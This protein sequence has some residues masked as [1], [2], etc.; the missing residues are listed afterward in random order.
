[1]P[2]ADEAP[3]GAADERPAWAG[4]PQSRFRHPSP[5]RFLTDRDLVPLVKV[6]RR[7]RGA[8]SPVHW[9]GENGDRPLFLPQLAQESPHLPPAVRQFR[10]AVAVASNIH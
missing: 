5:Q 9:L 2:Y 8:K 6:L 10:C 1:M 4:F 3:G 7:Q